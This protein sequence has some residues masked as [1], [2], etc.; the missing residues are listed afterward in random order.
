MGGQ[1]GFENDPE[2][3]AWVGYGGLS[4]PAHW[5]P[6]TSNMLIVSYRPSPLIRDYCRGAVQLDLQVVSPSNLF[7]EGAFRPVA[8]S[9]AYL[10]VA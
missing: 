4:T 3:Y 6:F 5:D 2:P 7:A 9:L 1:E 8:W 10:P